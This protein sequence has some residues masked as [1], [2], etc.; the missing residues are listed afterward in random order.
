MPTQE[1]MKAALRAYVDGFANGDAESVIAL[2][3]EDAVVEDPVGSP[4][5]HGLEA[6]GKFYRDAVDS[7]ARLTLDGPVRGSQ[8][9]GAAMAFT[10]ELAALN[11]TIKA[12]DVFTFNDAGKITTMRAYW[13]PDDMSQ[14]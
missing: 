1:E 7:G 2:F 10:I 5:L 14:G 4:E 9:S 12:I 6:I 3:A 8:G 11:L 13:G